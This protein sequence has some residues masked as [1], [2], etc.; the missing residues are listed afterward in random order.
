MKHLSENL[1][2]VG[3][4][5]VHYLGI[6]S[7]GM[8]R[9]L[10]FLN[11]IEESNHKVEIQ[12]LV[13]SCKK[14]N[15]LENLKS[16]ILALDHENQCLLIAI[17]RIFG[18]DITDSRDQR[19][20]Q[21]NFKEVEGVL[22]LNELEINKHE[23]LLLQKREEDAQ[24]TIVKV[25]L[26]ISVFVFDYFLRWGFLALYFNLKNLD[27]AYLWLGNFIAIP[28]IT[29]LFGYI[30]NVRTV[31]YNRNLLKAYWSE[32]EFKIKKYIKSWQYMLCSVFLISGVYIAYLLSYDSDAVSFFLMATS[33]GLIALY[34]V[35]YK[36]LSTGKISEEDF[37][38][39]LVI[40]AEVDELDADDNDRV[41]IG[42]ES[43]LKSI[44]DRLDTYVLESALFGALA[45]SGFLQIM[46]ENLINFNDLEKF[47]HNV[48]LLSV[49]VVTFARIDEAIL[50]ELGSKTS[51][52]CLISFETLL[53][54]VLF[55][56]VIA[57]RLR[58]SDYM[59][60]IGESISLS[61]NL[62]NKE[63]GLLKYGQV[64]EEAKERYKQVHTLIKEQLEST[65]YFM[66]KIKPIS[67]HM[68]FFRN[69]GIISFYIILISS[70]FFISPAIG[71]VF[72]LIG[73]VSVVYFNFKQLT[74][75]LQAVLLMAQRF[76]IN[77]GYIVKLVGFLLVLLSLIMTIYYQNGNMG[78]I[79]TLGIFLMAIAHIIS[80]VVIQHKDVKFDDPVRYKKSWTTI[81]VF[82]ALLESLA[83]V[84]IILKL[85]GAEGANELLIIGLFPLSFL[86]FAIALKFSTK[87]WFGL[88][89]GIIYWLGLFGLLFELLTFPGASKLSTLALLSFPV[90]VV[91]Y[92]FRRKWIHKTLL[93]M[94]AVLYF[95]AG[96]IALDMWGV[97][98]TAY[99][100]QESNITNI[101]RIGDDNSH[102]KHLR[103]VNYGN[104]KIHIDSL[105]WQVKE[106]AENIKWIT[107]TYPEVENVWTYRFILRHTN[108]SI[109]KLI[110]VYKNGDRYIDLGIDLI[111][112]NELLINKVNLASADFEDY[113]YLQ[114]L[115]DLGRKQEIQ[116]FIDKLV[117][118]CKEDE[119]DE[120]TIKMLE[121]FLK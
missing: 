62:N 48:H 107:T 100:F 9:W 56:A 104:D 55:L 64:K 84:G 85:N 88:L 115:V 61:H 120:E 11:Q 98:K 81:I 5:I 73:L 93:K 38:E 74:I 45:F 6:G 87:I 94:L 71:L 51:L 121:A 59:D 35:L 111:H 110:T 57:S 97:I 33:I 7:T 89:I 58:F 29:I 23:K 99:S 92:F 117:K 39:K 34:A 30:I 31:K 1:I 18:N 103:Y 101:Q 12:Q 76:F 8:V 27:E 4:S 83:V 15:T 54:S 16:E 116:S 95:L 78:Y 118:K 22:S 21:Y 86:M 91:V 82:W 53:C 70:S 46:A 52:F 90:I 106:V 77:Y 24:R 96:L 66:N 63:E 40:S 80:D 68:R 44:K 105:T 119:A 114:I 20:F 49:Q 72:I 43:N 75:Q 69:G 65:N 79:L 102:L 47:A 50:T 3:S 42:L 14:L 36:L 10:E 112:A 28:G 113:K 2:L 108:T 13:T 109:H 32:H 60:K 17:I 25:P 41:I 67:M 37:P 19:K 26:S